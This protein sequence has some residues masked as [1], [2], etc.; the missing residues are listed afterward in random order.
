MLYKQNDIRIVG[1]AADGVEAV[2]RATELCPDLILLDIG[3]PKLNGIDAARQ[4]RRASPQSKII[5]VSQETCID[6]IEEALGTGAMGYIVKSA[7]GS[8]LTSA[9]NLVMQGGCYFGG[10]NRPL[11]PEKSKQKEHA[12]RWQRDE[13]FHF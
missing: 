13:V 3:L 8:E 6:I 5:F 4:I 1:E 9:L 10:G 2:E 12:G 11:L 7:V